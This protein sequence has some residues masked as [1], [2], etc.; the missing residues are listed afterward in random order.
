MDALRIKPAVVA[1]FDWGART[2]CV[3]AALWP[4]RCR[5]LVSVSGYLISNLEDGKRPLPMG[6]GGTVF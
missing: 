5:A 4:E 3:V 6:E 2:V 1:G